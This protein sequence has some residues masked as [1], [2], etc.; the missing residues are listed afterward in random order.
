MELKG[1]TAIVTG[2]AR[3][4]GAGIATVLAREGANVV[5]NGL[6]DSDCVDVVKKI[7][8]AGGTA[9]GVGADISKRADVE[10]MVAAAVNKFGTDDILFNNAGIEGFPCNSRISPRNNGTGF[11]ASTSPA[12]FCA[13]RRSSR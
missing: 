1:K 4:I 12:C 3:G 5:V 13:A 11:S 10:K 7:A 2:S 8:A 9:I 6:A